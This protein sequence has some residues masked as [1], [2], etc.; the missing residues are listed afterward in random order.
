MTDKQIAVETLTRLPETASLAQITEE[1][2][3]MAAIREGQAD[4]AAGR[5]RPHTEVKQ[6]FSSWTERWTTTSRSSP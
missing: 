4:V 5:V 3:V 2:Q 6:L 1:L